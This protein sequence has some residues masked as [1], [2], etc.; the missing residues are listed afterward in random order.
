MKPP[1]A[2]ACWLALALMLSIGSACRAQTRDRDEPV[3]PDSALQEH[4]GKN[5]QLLNTLDSTRRLNPPGKL[6]VTLLAGAG[7]TEPPGQSATTTSASSPGAESTNSPAADIASGTARGNGQYFLSRQL[8]IGVELALAKSAAAGATGA[9]AV[10]LSTAASGLRNAWHWDLTLAY[11]SRRWPDSHR[12]DCEGG[13]LQGA[14]GYDLMTG[15]TRW[16]SGPS[17]GF[18]LSQLKLK[19]PR[20][21]AEPA[22]NLV[23]RAP[24]LMGGWFAQHLSSDRTL[25]LTVNLAL[26]AELE[27]DQEGFGVDLSGPERLSN[28]ELYA[29]GRLNLT[30]APSPLARITLQYEGSMRSSPSE[31]NLVVGII[32]HL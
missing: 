4:L 21:D 20:P 16:H 13:T 1:W 14:A 12:S 32:Y 25:A 31:Q 19:Q 18:A 11:E 23:I 3:A 6:Q 24:E 9:E 22:R 8:R 29:S 26:H 17:V 10:M 5:R 27:R 15:N 30:Y 28:P 2:N 7:R